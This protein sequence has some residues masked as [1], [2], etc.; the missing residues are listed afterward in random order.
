MIPSTAADGR[1]TIRAG[2][3]P[4]EPK[5]GVRM[6]K[7]LVVA[8]YTAEGMKGVVNKGGSARSDAVAKMIADQGGTMESFYFA[9]GDEDAYV[10]VDLPDNVAAAAIGMAV[11]ASGMA[12]CKTIVLLTPSEVDRAAEA[13]V[14]Y[15][16]PGS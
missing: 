5:R 8:S 2:D 12:A 1:A 11:G 3:E 13:G 7:Y 15:R 14:N 10:T 6:A 16:P 9:F 4:M